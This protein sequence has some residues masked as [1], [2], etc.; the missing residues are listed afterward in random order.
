MRSS[1]ARLM[2]R[3]IE[4]VLGNLRDFAIANRALETL[5][6]PSDAMNRRVVRV[7]SSLGD[8]ALVLAD[9]RLRDG[10][11]VY[12]DAERVIAVGVEPDDVI[13]ARPATIAAALDLAHAL[14]NRH[15]PV[16]REGDALIVRY[17]E[18]IALLCERA[19]VAWER[20]RRVLAEP[21]VAPAAP[22]EHAS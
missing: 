16:Q 14:G 20:T 5:A 22:H 13:V 19:G 18:P 3:R 7:A 6:V 8:L 21:F 4:R 11:V 17:S 9:R 2:H 12:E 15:L 1:D 10:D